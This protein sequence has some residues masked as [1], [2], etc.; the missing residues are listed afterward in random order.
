MDKLQESA[1]AHRLE[2]TEKQVK[3]AIVV[4]GM[5]RS[6]T[7][8]VTGVVVTL[9]AK[10]P[11]TLVPAL[12]ENPKGF[13]ESFALMHINDRVLDAL[14]SDWSDW[15]PLNRDWFKTDAC[16]SLI[17]DAKETLLQEYGGASL[18]AVK[19]PRMCRIFPF[20]M[21]VFD[22]LGYKPKIIIPIRS[23][24]E[25]AASL[26]QRNGFP[27]SKGLLLWLRHVLDAEFAT[28]GL[29]RAIVRWSELLKDWQLVTSEISE[30]LD[31]SWPSM[32]DRVSAKIDTFLTESL[33]HSSFSPARL[34]RH[35]LASG[36]VAKVHDAMVAL[37]ENPR[38]NEPKAIL[39]RVN[40]EFTTAANIFG[41]VLIEAEESGRVARSEVDEKNAA[42]VHLSAERDSAVSGQA[43]L[44]ARLAEEVK[45]R[46][47]F[48]QELADVR[49]Q[50]TSVVHERN[51][52]FYEHTET[53]RKLSEVSASHDNL[54]QTVNLLEDQLRTVSH[55]R[56]LARGEVGA[57]A[58]ERDL[59]VNQIEQMHAE[60]ETLANANDAN[61]EALDALAA[62][63]D[64]LATQIVRMHAELET[65]ANA[66]VANR[67]A[68]EALTAERDQLVSQIAQMHAEV[69]SLASANLV[70]REAIG[71][72]AAERDQLV[73][74]IAQMHA[75]V[76]RLANADV[77]NREAMEAL[78]AE[79]DQLASKVPELEAQLRESET[80]RSAALKHASQLI[81]EAAQ[82]ASDLIS[83][84][85]QSE[86]QI[87]Q[88]RDDI[89][90]SQD[91][92]VRAE[93]DVQALRLELESVKSAADA[94]RQQT[95]QTIQQMQATW[96]SSQEAYRNAVLNVDKLTSNISEIQAKHIYALA[97]YQGK[98][99]SMFKKM[100]LV[101]HSNG[102]M[103]VEIASS[104]LFDGE[105]YLSTY[106]DVAGKGVDPVAHYIEYGSREGRNPGPYFDGDRY[107][108]ANPD[109]KMADINPL[110]HFLRFGQYE[111]RPLGL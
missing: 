14:G 53:A 110:Y 95:R 64:Q 60:V 80:E 41:R 109:V 8:S 62:E 10:A 32:S 74:Q 43:E 19:D 85:D 47:Q 3:T 46:E 99:V 37:A 106:R 71:T 54:T 26:R 70:N 51:H 15:R 103:Y 13:F 59:L 76:D 24:L 96:A 44:S 31:L 28:R 78:T 86:A 56:D 16:T 17:E 91:A 5:H 49:E 92:R 35:P 61:R 66:D 27:T 73:N 21:R 101:L 9:G 81:G 72:L 39:D 108:D 68:I 12:D 50:L 84:K 104:L 83:L 111:N 67:E 89:A 18:I 88:L 11:A 65:L 33:R 36:W 77:A 57:L 105:W 29:P 90:I 42:L 52:A 1:A 69:A 40:R 63:R 34:E 4:L 38:A 7:S 30:Q 98:R 94:E 45:S 87:H 100:G 22:E 82:L 93:R 48:C 79:R 2:R 55:E 97:R 23:P 20:W 107:L 75:D 58:A 102:T 6:G 25:V